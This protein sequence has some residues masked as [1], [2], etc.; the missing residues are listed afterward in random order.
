MLVEMVVSS[1]EG[2]SRKKRTLSRYRA[3]LTRLNTEWLETLRSFPRVK[4]LPRR[5]IWN[6]N[7]N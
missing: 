6:R 1:T 2:P 7:F 5:I 3:G 4:M